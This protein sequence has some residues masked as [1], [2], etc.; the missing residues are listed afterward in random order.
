VDSRTFRGKR[1]EP[2]LTWSNHMDMFY[3]GWAVEL[4]VE[5]MAN[6]ERPYG[7]LVV[8]PGLEVFADYDR[9]LG[10]GWGTGSDMDPTRHSEIFAIKEACDIR[11]EL[12]QGCIL[13]STHEPCIMCCGAINHAKLSRV[14]WG[15][16]RED[17]PELFRKRNISATA[18][19]HD[20]SHPPDL[21]AGL[22]RKRCADLFRGLRRVD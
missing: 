11:G 18:L 22:M 4:A 6:G 5:A 20:T 8:D 10:K 9:I 19:L 15:S 7:A 3:M 21:Y 17:L 12:L 16:F 2:G 13:Y 14:V 1:W